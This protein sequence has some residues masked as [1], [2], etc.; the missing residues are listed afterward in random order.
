MTQVLHPDARQYVDWFIA[1][2]LFCDVA[3]TE[4]AFLTD[5]SED[6]CDLLVRERVYA[7][8]LSNFANAFR[9]RPYRPAKWLEHVTVE[10]WP[11]NR[12]PE[13]SY[14]ITP[15]GECFWRFQPAHLA[16]TTQ[17]TR[18]VASVHLDGNRDEE[19][20]Q[21]LDLA[22]E[23]YLEEE[24][25]D[26]TLEEA[27]SDRIQ[28][29]VSAMN[30]L[31]IQ[32]DDQEFCYT[33]EGSWPDL[34]DA[35]VLY[36][37]DPDDDATITRLPLTA[38]TGLTTAGWLLKPSYCPDVFTTPCFVATATGAIIPLHP[39]GDSTSGEP[40]QSLTPI[41]MR[42]RT[43]EDRDLCEAALQA[44]E[45]TMQAMGIDLD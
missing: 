9:P 6:D 5:A 1:E 3:P 15:T 8:D 45:D 39:L 4:V 25:L 7:A 29:F 11:I 41:S 18:P 44:L 31:G 34:P 22:R 37:I 19:L 20:L 40:P 30:V 14:V 35:T 12:G 42:V 24:F 28:Q 27:L 13:A 26:R 21:N 38:A 10:G 33:L 23:T 32:P 2:M 36:S 16:Q 17:A 43:A